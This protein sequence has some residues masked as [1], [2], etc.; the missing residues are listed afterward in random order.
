MSTP[1]PD[2]ATVRA[3][4]RECVTVVQP[5][6]VLVMR[7]KHLDLAGARRIREIVRAWNIDNGTDLKVLP[8]MADELT[9]MPADGVIAVPLTEA[10][11]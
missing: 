5:G 3:L 9:V 10:S 7:F 1:V 2:D 4:L 6:E 8:L 11:P